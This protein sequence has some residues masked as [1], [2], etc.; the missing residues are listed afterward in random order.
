MRA[1]WKGS[2]SFGLVNIP[3]QLYLASHE[4]ELSFVLL[5][6][7]DLSQIRYARMCKAEDKEVPWEEIVKGYEYE[8]GE[9]VVLQ[10]KD[11]EQANLKKTQTIEIVHFIE[12]EEV[13]PVYYVKPYYLEPAKGAEKAYLLLREALAKT[14]KV[15]IARYV[16]RTR[17]HLAVIKI[18]ENV[19]ILNE[20]RFESEFASL[21]ELNIPEKGKPNPKEVAMAIELI[22]TLT[23]PFNPKKYKDTYI[24]EM[25]KIIKQ[26]AKGKR[27]HPKTGKLQSTKI[28][29]IM[30]QLQA[31]LKK[32]GIKKT[33]KRK[34][35]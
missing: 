10:D 5:H 24:E 25:K 35:A 32:K 15:G 7:K 1:I 6:K 8:K 3:V 22:D 20:L 26:K 21:K 28:H 13:D 9:F 4:R 17:E 18:H 19:L 30:T 2:I 33:S 34:T 11:F 31:S 14:K 27:I 16:L 12:E 23:E 29:D